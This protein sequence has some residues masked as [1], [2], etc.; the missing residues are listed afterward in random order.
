YYRAKQRRDLHPSCPIDAT[1]SR[2]RSR[3]GRQV[4]VQ[5]F[6]SKKARINLTHA[7]GLSELMRDLL[8][9]SRVKGIQQSLAHRRLPSRKLIELGRPVGSL[10]YQP[11]FAVLIHGQQNSLQA[12]DQRGIQIFSDGNKMARQ[13]LSFS[14]D[15]YVRLFRL[16]ESGIVVVAKRSSCHLFGENQVDEFVLRIGKN[17][18]DFPGRNVR[19]DSGLLR[20]FKSQPRKEELRKKMA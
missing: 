6:A 1:N 16:A 9:L 19:F 3:S 15:A 11:A 20:K 4:I 7:L 2:Q 5:F 14:Q 13:L 10:Q 12:V 8:F 18:T 17:V